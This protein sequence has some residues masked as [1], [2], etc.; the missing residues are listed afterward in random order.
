MKKQGIIEIIVGILG[1]AI[2]LISQKQEW[3]YIP[4]VLYGILS[5]V[6]V[7]RM[8]ELT[9]DEEKNCRRKRNI[10]S[11]ISLPIFAI[12]CCSIIGIYTFVKGIFTLLYF[13]AINKTD[14]EVHQFMLKNL[15]N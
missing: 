4:L 9:T 7:R 1:I 2:L 6:M 13:G 14:N 12:I 8:D 15:K 3:S 11:L 5:V 10:T